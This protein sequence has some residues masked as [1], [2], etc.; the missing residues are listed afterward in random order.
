MFGESAGALV[1]L[2]LT[3]VLLSEEPGEDKT[4]RLPCPVAVEAAASPHEAAPAERA[5][6][7]ALRVEPA[8]G[9]GPSCRPAFA[10]F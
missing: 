9:P 3:T 4:A 6:A 7:E 1:L 5:R 10:S 8:A 2:A